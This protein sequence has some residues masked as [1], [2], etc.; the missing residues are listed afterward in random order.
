M[1][2]AAMS[3][4]QLAVDRVGPGSVG[5]LAR[6]RCPRCGTALRGRDVLPVAGFL[7][8]R[9]SCRGCAGEIP[10]RHLVGELGA[11]AFWAVA[12][13]VTGPAWW[14]PVVLVVPVTVV[15]LRSSLRRAGGRALAAGLLPPLGVALL[16]LGLAGA[17]EAR[18]GLYGVAGVLGT[19][20]LL[21]A[22]LA[23]R[24]RPAVLSRDR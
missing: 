18:W 19:A 5:L 10:R 16:T 9:G 11:A 20:S 12:M 2:A 1:G 15:L 13:L 6:S 24:G 23:A 8:L 4:A 22:V 14:L 17:L 3:F 21:A 7:L